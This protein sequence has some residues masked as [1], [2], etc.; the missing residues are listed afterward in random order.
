MKRGIPL[1]QSKWVVEPGCVVLVTGGRLAKANAMTISWQ[2]PVNTADPC[3]VLLVMG[4]TR[5]TYELIKQNNQLVINVPGEE[6]LEQTHLLGTVSGRKVDKF[7]KT[8]LTLEP[9]KLVA[10]PWIAQCAGHLECQIVETFSVQTHD[11]LVC[12]V[13]HAAAEEEFFDGAWIPE[14]FHTLHYMQKTQYGVLTRRL[15]AAT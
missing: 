6:L 13:V 7:Q 10:P 9:A 14:K 11:L 8:G 12:E 5:Y 1:N 4:R 3:L 15:D 2:T